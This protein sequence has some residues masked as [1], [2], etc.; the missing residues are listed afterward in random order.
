M[1]VC[2]VTCISCKALYVAVCLFVTL[3]FF[4]L[5]LTLNFQVG[6][7][8]SFSALIIF[9]KLLVFITHSLHLFTYK[10]LK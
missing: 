1:S 9:H 8:F 6:E 3:L 5:P 2:I 4:D 10:L 7:V